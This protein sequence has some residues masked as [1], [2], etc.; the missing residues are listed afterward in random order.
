MQIS[1]KRMTFHISLTTKL[2]FYH[3]VLGLFYPS[4]IFMRINIRIACHLI[5]C[6]CLFCI[7][8]ALALKKIS[9]VIELNRLCRLAFRPTA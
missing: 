3:A 9:D 4:R 6:I 1:S 5:A 7:L 8:F 2:I